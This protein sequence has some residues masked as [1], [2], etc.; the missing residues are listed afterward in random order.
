[1]VRLGLFGS[2]INLD[3]K[4]FWLKKIF[5]PEIFSMKNWV[6][7]NLGSKKFWAK[8]ILGK[9]F[10]VK[11]FFGLKKCFGQKKFGSKKLCV[12]KKIGQKDLDP[13]FCHTRLHLGFSV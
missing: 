13:I 4:K 1:M 2:Q 10:C 8:K 6:K 9:K 11:F 3:K 12:K 7:K 5:G